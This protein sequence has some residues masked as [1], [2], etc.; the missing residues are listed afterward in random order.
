M[1][2]NIQYLFDFKVFWF[3]VAV[4]VT[5]SIFYMEMKGFLNEVA[6]LLFLVIVA[7][8]VILIIIGRWRRGVSF[9]LSGVA[10]LVWMAFLSTPI[11]NGGIWVRQWTQF[12][13][14]EPSYIAEAR[15]GRKEW[16]WGM[17][18]SVHYRLMYDASGDVIGTWH[19]PDERDPCDRAV[20]SLGNSF[21]VVGD[22]CPG[23]F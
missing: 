22:E 14:K 16:D 3:G 7:L 15:G 12:K 2:K 5:M 10:L 6:F 20:K 19:R 13:I 9:V 1:K 23:I 18:G 11:L 21:Y 8:G 17:G 4:Y